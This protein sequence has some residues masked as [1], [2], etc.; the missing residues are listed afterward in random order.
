MTSLV[1]IGTMVSEAGAK[2]G[3]RPVSSFLVAWHLKQPSA[4]FAKVSS[5]RDCSLGQRFAQTS[6][7][8]RNPKKYQD[9]HWRT[10]PHHKE[11]CSDFRGWGGLFLKSVLDFELLLSA[12]VRV[13]GFIAVNHA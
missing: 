10:C 6:R 4:Q 7:Q 9:Q 8:I 2:S 5:R 12:G 1:V 13:S 3:H 11:R